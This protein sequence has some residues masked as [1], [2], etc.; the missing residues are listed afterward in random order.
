MLEKQRSQILLDR[1][2]EWRLKS[3]AIWLLTGDENTKKFHNF[4][5]DRRTMNTIWKLKDEEGREANTFES[6]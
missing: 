5:K 6:L 3:R 1:E 2:E 4:A